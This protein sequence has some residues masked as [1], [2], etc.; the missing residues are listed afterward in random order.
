[1]RHPYLV[2]F[3]A[4]IAVSA[5]APL[6]KY[7]EAADA[8]AIGFWRTFS[9]G[10]LLAATLKSS[11]LN[12]SKRDM[13][14]G[15]VAGLLLALHFWTWFESLNYISVLRSTTLVCLSPIWAGLFEAILFKQSPAR[16]FWLGAT[17][18]IVGSAIMSG[19]GEWNSDLFGDSLAIIGGMLSAAYLLIGRSVRQRVD[20]QPYGALICLSSACG[21][22]VAAMATN[23]QLWG[24]D[25]GIWL[26]LAAMALGPQL[27]GHIGFNYAIKNIKAS[28]VTLLLL[29]E[30]VG[31]ALIAWILLDNQTPEKMEI[32]GSAVIIMGLFVGLSGK[33]KLSAR[34]EDPID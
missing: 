5:A 29:L 15:C 34:K 22:F 28:T 20:I 16:A 8:I 33:K 12:M 1:M 10:I 11:H 23:T 17:L 31:A 14:F 27:L 19:Q 24:F 25:E 9:I 18:A 26:T 7:A 13:G 21:L 3:T 6:A 2:L 30:P 4:V 32:I